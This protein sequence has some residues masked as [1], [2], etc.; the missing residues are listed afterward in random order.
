MIKAETYYEYTDPTARIDALARALG[1][2]FTEG[3]YVKEKPERTFRKV[4]VNATKKR[5]EP[6]KP[7]KIVRTRETSMIKE[8]WERV[9]ALGVG[10]EVNM[11][12]IM[13]ELNISRRSLTKRL[14]T[15]QWMQ[16]KNGHNGTWRTVKRGWETYIVR[17][18]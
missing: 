10:E 16:R 4:K 8:D 2:H 14:S 12:P 6:K 17:T 1:L 9:R 15:W 5:A 11:S 18:A 7:R 3:E 13:R